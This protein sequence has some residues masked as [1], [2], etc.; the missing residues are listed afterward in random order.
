MLGSYREAIIENALG[1]GPK[2][3][4]GTCYEQRSQSYNRFATVPAAQ[5]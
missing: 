5:V 1:Y 4:C 2:P 3:L